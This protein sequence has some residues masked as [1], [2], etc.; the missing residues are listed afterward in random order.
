MPVTQLTTLAAAKASLQIPTSTTT[1][2]PLIEQ[3]I[4]QVSYAAQE[5]MG[6]TIGLM[7]H[8]NEILVGNNS[9]YIAVKNRPVVL[10]DTLQVWYDPGAWWGQAPDAF[11]TSPPSTLLQRGTDYALVTDE[12]GGTVSRSG[13][14]ANI[15]TGFWAAPICRT[16]GLLSP[17]L[18]QMGNI[19]VNSTAGYDPVPGDLAMGA[20]LCIANVMRMGRYGIP[21]TSE[22]MGAYSWSGSMWKT[23]DLLAPMAGIL[24]KYMNWTF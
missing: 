2:D 19:R 8:E 7:Y 3:L 4:S 14:L 5:R 22:S 10:D 11:S 23:D 16:P 20:N 18:G 1:L 6:R 21:V 12:P 17:F 13:L 24:A 9:L 15:S